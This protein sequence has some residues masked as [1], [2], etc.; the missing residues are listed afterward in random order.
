MVFR[1][2]H[3]AT[4]QILARIRIALIQCLLESGIVHVDVVIEMHHAMFRNDYG[5]YTTI[6]KIGWASV[7]SSVF[8]PFI[9]ARI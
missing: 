2:C 5:P 9:A 4:P 7:T 8:V 1:L 3:A 6:T